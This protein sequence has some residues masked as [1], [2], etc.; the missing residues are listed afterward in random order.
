[1]V[2]LNNSLVT[3]DFAQDRSGAGYGKKI[4][5][6]LELLSKNIDHIGVIGYVLTFQ[7]QYDKENV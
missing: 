4:N 2:S 5:H 3:Y 1:M 6:S 7:D